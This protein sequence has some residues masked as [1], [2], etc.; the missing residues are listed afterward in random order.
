MR[1]DQIWRKEQRLWLD[2]AAFFEEC[3]GPDALLVLPRGVIDRRAGVAVARWML[4]WADVKLS[5]QRSIRLNADTAILAYEA[6]AERAQADAPYRA[7]CSSTYVRARG[8]WLLM[9]HHRTDMTEHPPSLTELD[10]LR[11]FFAA[12]ANAV[13]PG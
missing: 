10:A 9:A 6:H 2:T 4:P 1:D 11:L 3:V 13:D 12:P 5:N 7:C 8:S